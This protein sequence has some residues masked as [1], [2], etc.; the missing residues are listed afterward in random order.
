MKTKRASVA[1]KGVRCS[2][3]KALIVVLLSLSIGTPPDATLPQ[4]IHR[5]DGI[6][7][8]G[9]QTLSRGTCFYWGGHASS[10]N[11]F[12]GL[13]RKDSPHGPIFRK[14][15]K[16]LKYY[17]ER[18]QVVIRVAQHECDAREV[19]ALSSLTMS[20][21]FAASLRFSAEWKAGAHAEPGKNLVLLG[22]QHKTRN[23]DLGSEQVLSDVLE[24]SFNLDCHEIPLTSHLIIKVTDSEDTQLVRLSAFP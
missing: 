2:C 23:F 15:G 24:Y 14:G 16:V 21:D 10:G 4:E 22:F 20:D 12:H 6:D 3:T 5:S 7:F 19:P 18:L 17:P 8:G 9:Q 1:S 11:Y 13:T